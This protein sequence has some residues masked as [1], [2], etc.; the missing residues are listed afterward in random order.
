VRQG[1]KGK[2]KAWYFCPNCG[3]KLL[4]YDVQEGESRRI[5]IKC[6]KCKKEVEINIE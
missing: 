5:F 1:V 4:K 3:Q 2:D 6:K